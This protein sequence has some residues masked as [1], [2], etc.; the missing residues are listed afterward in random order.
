VDGEQTVEPSAG[1]V[2]RDADRFL[3]GRHR[4]F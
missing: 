3:R 1:L 4:Q 2:S